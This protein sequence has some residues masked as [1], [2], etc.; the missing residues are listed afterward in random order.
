MASAHYPDNGRL[1]WNF[2]AYALVGLP[3]PAVYASLTHMLAP[4]E[5]GLFRF[6]VAFSFAGPHRDKVRAIA[7]IVVAR[8]GDGKVFF[9]EWFEH[10]ILGDDMDVLLQRFYHEQS[11]MVVADLSD[12][13]AGRPWCQAEARAIRALRF[14]I[15]PARDETGRLRL[16]NVKFGDGRVPGLFKTTAYLDGIHKTAEECAELILKR[17]ALLGQRMAVKVGSPEPA[18]AHPGPAA[19][20]TEET[21]KWVWYSSL[22]SRAAGQVSV[23]ACMETL[24]AVALYWWIAIRYDTHW[25]LVSSVCI[26]PLLLLRSP[27]SMATGVRWF[28]KDWFGFNSYEQWLKG[29]RACWFGALA[30]VSALPTYFFAHWLSHRWLPG[31]ER[32]SLFGWAAAIEASS[33][34]GAYLVA[35]ASA[36]VVAG[37]GA[38][39]AAGAGAVA[40][41]GMVAGEGAGAFA[42]AGAVTGAAVGAFVGASA[43]AGAVVGAGAIAGAVA[44]AV[45]GAV[46]GAGAIA[47]AVTAFGRGAGAGLAVRGLLLR[48][49]ATLCY[50]PNGIKRVPENWRENNFLTDSFLPAELMP[51]IRDYRPT[52]SL[53]GLHKRW[54]DEQIKSMWLSYALAG[55]IFFL[56]AFIYRLNIKATAWFWWPLAYLLKSAPVADA[57][58]QQKQALCWPWTNP[59]QKLWIIVSVL[60]TVVSLTLHNLDRAALLEVANLPAL[61]LALKVLLAIDWAHLS[62]WHWAQWIIAGAGAGMLALA[63]NARSHD[64]NGNW[65]E[66]RQRWPQNI[67]L[68]TG[69]QRLRTLATT[70]LLLMALG[71]LLLQDRTWQTYVSVPGNWLQSLEQFYSIRK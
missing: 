31:L 49:L 60:L 15:D 34:V 56:P 8:L 9:D 12:E 33:V 68:M 22:A 44:G 39:A 16:L 54:I 10:E 13:Y 19:P 48:V 18:A 24:C 70:A 43:I 40:G 4:R 2:G 55:V 26:A 38:G 42:L 23:L 27:E 59:F 17:H 57:E 36:G 46:V 67:R 45:V 63:G 25:H 51:G 3:P 66:Y 21:K 28:L 47:G 32:G 53:D 50:I 69:L 52:L 14:D 62:P 6:D 61:P 29:K 11:L 58:G 5:S 37:A 7:E 20:P 71:A 64:V 30:L 41:E 65:R 1:S 35:G